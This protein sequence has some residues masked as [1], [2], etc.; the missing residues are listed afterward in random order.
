MDLISKQFKTNKRFHEDKMPVKAINAASILRNKEI[1]NADYIH[2]IF[3][4][5]VLIFNNLVPK[6]GNVL[7]CNYT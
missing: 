4:A 2:S 1:W 6:Y 5:R 3:Q 7:S